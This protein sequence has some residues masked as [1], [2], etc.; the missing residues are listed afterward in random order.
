MVP[1][2]ASILIG[3]G[4]KV[5]LGL[6][7]TAAKKLMQSPGAAAATPSFGSFLKTDP[8][9]PS[10]FARDA[11]SGTGSPQP[12]ARVPNDLPGRLTAERLHGLDP[13]VEAQRGFGGPALTT[14]WYDDGPLAVYRRVGQA[15]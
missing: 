7:A 3:V 6:A 13:S 1:I 2:L 9:N 4:V 12:T 10:T 5:G 14:N 11:A 8:S 15:P